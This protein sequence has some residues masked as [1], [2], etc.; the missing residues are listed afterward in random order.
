M[1]K[2][3]GRG[4]RGVEGRRG[5]SGKTGH[6]KTGP[7]GNPGLRG[8]TGKKGTTGARGKTGVHGLAGTL[9]GSEHEEILIL[10]RRIE[11]VYEALAEQMQHTAKIQKEF[12]AFRDKLRTLTRASRS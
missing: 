1:S 3:S 7:R 11:D 6:G 9:A 5:P 4:Q 12:D 10:Q 2:S 8:R